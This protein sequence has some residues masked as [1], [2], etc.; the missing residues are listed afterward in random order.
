MTAKDSADLQAGFEADG[1]CFVSLEYEVDLV[2]VVVT[3]LYEYVS[4]NLERLSYAFV[5]EVHT[6]VNLKT[7]APLPVTVYMHEAAFPESGVIPVTVH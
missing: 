7:V 2:M 1:L 4:M 5:D 6:G 3:G